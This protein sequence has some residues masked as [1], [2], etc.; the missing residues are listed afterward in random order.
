[1][2]AP[3]FRYNDQRDELV[4]KTVRRVVETTRD[5]LLSLNDAAYHE[6]RR[7]DGTRRPKDIERLEAWRSLAR[8]LGR[9]SEDERRV[10]LEHIVTEYARDIA[11]NFNPRVYR[12]A[13]RLMPSLVT[14][15]LSPSSLPSLLRDP[16]KLLSIDALAS[17][18]L[19]QGDGEM[20]RA[21]A[22]RGTLVFM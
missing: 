10:E 14:S 13:T 6:A 9:T 8:R 5:T 22:E 15:L 19:V 12:V 4:D 21:L 20:L 18:V 3:I 1:M 17:K 7:L 11:G 16:R 2:Q